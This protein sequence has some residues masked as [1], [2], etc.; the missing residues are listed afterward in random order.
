MLNIASFLPE[1]NEKYFNYCIPMEDPY[2][3]QLLQG[4]L[5]SSRICLL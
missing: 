1:P 3:L 5:Q 2:P 4:S